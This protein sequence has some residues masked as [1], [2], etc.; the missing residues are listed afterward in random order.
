MAHVFVSYLREDAELVTRLA[1]DLRGRG[2]TVWL[3]KD[4]LASVIRLI[5][6]QLDVSLP[7]ALR[8]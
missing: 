4:E 7:E 5:Q 8:R 2:A 1:S 6:S 3:D